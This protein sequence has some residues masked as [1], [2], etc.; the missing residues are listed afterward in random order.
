MTLG[1]QI[2]LENRI[3]SV[4]REFLPPCALNVVDG[5]VPT[6]EYWQWLRQQIADVEQEA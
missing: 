4:G 6:E 5:E 3:L 2:A 1:E